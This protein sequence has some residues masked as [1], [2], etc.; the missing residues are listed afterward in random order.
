MLAVPAVTWAQ[1]Q[2]P[3]PP[4]QVPQYG[5]PG[6]GG[7]YATGSVLGVQG[8]YEVTPSGSIILHPATPITA[9]GVMHTILGMFGGNGLIGRRGYFRISPAG[10]LFLYVPPGATWPG[11]TGPIPPAGGPGVPPQQPQ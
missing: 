11:M 4:Q 1:Q 8:Y 9:P 3:Q 2:P 7:D 10:E 6:M 5:I